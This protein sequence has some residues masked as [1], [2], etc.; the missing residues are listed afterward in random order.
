MP[1]PTFVVLVLLGVTAE[2]EGVVSPYGGGVATASTV[3][4][5][6]KG[7]V[8]VAVASP[9]GA[10]RYYEVKIDCN[11]TCKASELL[12]VLV[13]AHGGGMP[14]S[15]RVHKAHTVESGEPLYNSEHSGIWWTP[16]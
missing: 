16:L 6:Y 11:L 12:L 2:E 10:N 15:H 4:S 3:V 13:L 7:D 5:G 14:S 9:F 1:D 8:G